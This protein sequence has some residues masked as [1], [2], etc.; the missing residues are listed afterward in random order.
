MKQL[1]LKVNNE[2]F[3]I[4]YIQGPQNSPILHW[5]HANGF[6]G[7]TYEN[8]LKKLSRFCHI[9][10]WDAR[11]HGLNFKLQQPAPTKIYHQY[12]DDL[13][14]LINL[15]FA[16]H[17]KPIILAGHSFGATICIKAEQI[18]KGKVSKLLIAD[19]VLF[20]PFAARMSQILRFLK[21][22]KPREI[23]L[24]Q[25]AAKRQ[26]TWPTRDDAFIYLKK[27]SLFKNWDNHTLQNYIKYGTVN[28]TNGTRLSCSRNLESLIFQES[29][30]EFLFEEIEGLSV[31]THV[32]FA[33]QG[34]PAFAKYKFRKSKKTKTAIK[35]PY[36]NHLFPINRYDEF[37]NKVREHIC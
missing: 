19:P 24:A 16:K 20:T 13:V 8:L 17:S 3:N 6:N 29:E 22:K 33:S 26:D 11:G 1:Q 23:Y 2:N 31:N 4:W 12:T 35:I 7:A 9:Y 32:Y 14:G 25:N 10:A 36:S 30:T 5:S 21:F 27:K 34:S 28:I 37:S 15:L 18:L